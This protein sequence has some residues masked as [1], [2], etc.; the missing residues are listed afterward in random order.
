LLVTSIAPDAQGFL[1]ELQSQLKNQ[2]LAAFIGGVLSLPPN[3]THISKQQL[4]DLA[5]KVKPIDTEYVVELA[6]EIEDPDLKIMPPNNLSIEAL[7]RLLPAEDPIVVLRA[8][9]Q[10]SG[11][12]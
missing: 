5:A 10:R 4:A 12:H 7:K 6:G 1:K 2:D 11:I 3:T 8:H 9:L